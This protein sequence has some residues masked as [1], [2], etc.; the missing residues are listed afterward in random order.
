MCRI[1]VAFISHT[2][3]EA[4]RLL[5]A[6]DG[7]SQ[8]SRTAWMVVQVAQC[9]AYAT[10]HGHPALTL[11]IEIC[12]FSPSLKIRVPRQKQPFLAHT[13]YPFQCHV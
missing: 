5:E 1:T 8:P 10:I 13:S 4:E 6:Q 3:E 12:P 2:G 11:P 9:S 7:T